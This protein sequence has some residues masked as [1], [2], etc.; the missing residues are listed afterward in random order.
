MLSSGE[1]AS[2]PITKYNCNQNILDKE[3][4]ISDENGIYETRDICNTNCNH[5]WKQCY[6]KLYQD[7]LTFINYDITDTDAIIN[8]KT[9]FNLLIVEIN[10]IGIKPRQPVLIDIARPAIA[11]IEIV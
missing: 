6:K 11:E 4:C 2:V 7:I 1:I 10:K 9:Q 3:L 5:I 8:L